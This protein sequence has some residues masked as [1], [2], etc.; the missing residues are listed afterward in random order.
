VLKLV[1]SL[2]KHCLGFSCPINSA[3]GENAAH[4]SID[5]LPEP[6]TKNSLIALTHCPTFSS[7][8]EAA[9]LP[10]FLRDYRAFLGRR[11]SIFGFISYFP[12]S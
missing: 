2:S 7:P 10:K 6:K 3:P 5:F 11:V 12:L 8:A 1:L 9:G 4:F